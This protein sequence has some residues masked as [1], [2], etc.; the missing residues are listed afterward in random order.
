MLTIPT[1]PAETPLELGHLDTVQPF[2]LDNRHGVSEFSMASLYPF[3]K[4][5]HYTISTY[6]Q[7]DGKP[8]FLIRG[9]QQ[10]DG[11]EETF[12]MIPGGFPGAAILEDL[13]TRVSEINA[14]SEDLQQNWEQGIAKCRLDLIMSEDRDNADYIYRRKDLIELTGKNLHKKLVHAHH[15]TEDHPDRILIPSHIAKSSD[16]I[17]ILDKW[18]EGKDLVED[19]KATLLAIECRNELGLKG[20][21]LYTGDEPVAFTLGEEDGFSRFIIH[22]EKAIGGL[23]G[24]YQYINRAFAAE[25]PE[26]IIEINREQDLGIP[27]LRQAKK[28]YSPSRLLMKYKIRKDSLI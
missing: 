5:R 1:Y 2:L 15:F 25:L 12:A 19:Y 24:V 28:T 6:T 3:T 26:K 4:K 22:I 18:A 10:N 16:M 23:R 13:F 20:V 27:G 11:K 14:I 17:E 21:V 7:S 8:C 9:L